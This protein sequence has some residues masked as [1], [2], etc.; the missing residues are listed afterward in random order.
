MALI[1]QR[2]FGEDVFI[3]YA[4]SDGARYAAALAK[5]LS[6]RDFT[7]FLDQ[8]A[9]PRGPGLPPEISRVLK[10]AKSLVLVGTQGAISSQF[11]AAELAAFASQLRIIVPINI[12]QCLDGAPWDQ[13]P[14]SILSGVAQALDSTGNLHAGTPS[15]ET[16]DYIQNSFLFARRNR[17][18][19][20]PGEVG[21]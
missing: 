2:L 3:S 12:G 6:D 14:W 8:W 11:V 13:R 16:V 7:C 5:Q 19:G 10:R 9:S 17:R 18:V 20:I 1:L 21:H 15:A 4:R